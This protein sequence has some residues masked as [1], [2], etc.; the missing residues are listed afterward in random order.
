MSNQKHTPE[1]WVCL[2]FEVHDCEQNIITDCLPKEDVW[3]KE[4][5][6]ANAVRI[7]ACVNYCKGTSNE[8]L[9]AG[10]LEKLKAERDELIQA[11][12]GARPFVQTFADYDDLDHAELLARISNILKKTN[13]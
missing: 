9:E 2:E 8:E 3:S 7:V 1:P 11:L 12:K 5:C 13:P 10:S 6:K 4:R